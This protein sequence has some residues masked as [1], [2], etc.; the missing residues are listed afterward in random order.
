MALTRRVK[1]DV[2]LYH[3]MFSDDDEGKKRKEVFVKQWG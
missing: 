3:L 1:N 2:V